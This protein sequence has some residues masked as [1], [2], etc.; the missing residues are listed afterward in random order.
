MASTYWTETGNADAGHQHIEL[1]EKQLLQTRDAQ[2]SGGDKLPC[3][4]IL[5]KSQL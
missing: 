5:V 1:H 2:L 4:Q 3:S